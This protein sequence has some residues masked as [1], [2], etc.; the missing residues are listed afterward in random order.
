MPRT[1]EHNYA[2]IV[3]L[4]RGVQ[5][6]LEEQR[7][8]FNGIG[9]YSDSSESLFF[10]QSKTLMGTYA[11]MII[12]AKLEEDGYDVYSVSLKGKAGARYWREAYLPGAKNVGKA[13]LYVKDL[14]KWVEVKISRSYTSPEGKTYEKKRLFF[15]WTWNHLS[16]RRAAD[17]GKFD[18]LVLVGIN[19]LDNY[20]GRPED[21]FYWILNRE[22]ASRIE[23]EGGTAWEKNWWFFMVDEPDKVTDISQL[24][25]HPGSLRHRFSKGNLDNAKRGLKALVSVWPSMRNGQRFVSLQPK[26]EIR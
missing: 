10:N 19:S 15:L 12:A 26:L 11:E 3:Q 9:V 16:I 14:Q 25:W 13:D 21:L 4:L 20:V 7:N 23:S 5:E 8:D 18:F 2:K 24:P 17:N 1:G 6:F 22:E